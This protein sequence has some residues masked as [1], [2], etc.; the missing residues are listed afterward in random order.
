M[1]LITG[2]SG[3]TGQAILRALA[4]KRVSARAFVRHPDQA[5]A[6]VSLGAEQAIVGD[7]RDEEAVRRAMEGTRSVYHICPNVSPDEVLIGQIAA[8]A[9]RAAGVEHFIYH[10]VLHPQVEAMPHHWNKLRVEE[11]LFESGLP[12]TILQPAIYMQNVLTHWS[13]I[14]E[15]GLY[16]VPYP[17]ETRLSLV[18]L[19]DVAEAAANV[20][21]ELGHIRATYEL[22]GT[23]AM[24]QT[25]V[26]ETLTSCLGQAIQIATVSVDTWREQAEAAGMGAYQVAA[27]IKMFDYYARQGLYGNANILGW[28]IHRTPTSFMAFVQRTLRERNGLPTLREPA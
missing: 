25:D 28:L 15:Q 26:V 12:F 24:A 1:I 20:L 16:A 2:A 8:R 11:L 5:R 14:S 22:V 13:H 4:V 7:L 9:A 3:K 23:R 6:V 21:T 10:S 27:L 18:D 19:E 17:P